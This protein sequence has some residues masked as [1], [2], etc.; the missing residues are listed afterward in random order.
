MPVGKDHAL[1]GTLIDLGGHNIN[2]AARL[3]LNHVTGLDP[4]PDGILGINLYI[5]IRI[6]PQ[7]LGH[8]TGHTHGMPVI[9]N[10]AG[11]EIER[12]LGI[13]NFLGICLG[14]EPDPQ[15][16]I[17]VCRSVKLVRQIIFRLGGGHGIHSLNKLLYGS[18]CLSI[19]LAGRRPL[20]TIRHFLQDII[21]GAPEIVIT[22][23][24]D[25]LGVLIPDRLGQ[26]I[27]F[28]LADKG[29]NTFFNHRITQFF[30]Q[31]Q[32]PFAD[33]PDLRLGLTWCLH[34]FLGQL[35][36][37]LGAAVHSGFFKM[38]GRGQNKIC[39]LRGQGRKN[40]R[41]DDKDILPRHT[42]II[43]ITVG[44]TLGRAGAVNPD[45]L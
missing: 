43:Q 12:I 36:T 20:N 6:G 1:N 31:L 3:Q 37:A 15:G 26:L 27:A 30:R 44:Q 11:G 35:R 45:G 14:P 25:L 32:G 8:S 4:E 29:L 38:K 40:I 19:L 28:F 33:D 18:A 39:R 21:G 22:P 23:L 7:Q 16:A 41:T 9:N 5:G 42:F 13:R 24:G 10:T 34:R 17:R 2:T